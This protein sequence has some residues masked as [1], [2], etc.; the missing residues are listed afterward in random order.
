MSIIYLGN[1][2]G[3]KKSPKKKWKL[4]HLHTQKYSFKMKLQQKLFGENQILAT[5]KFKIQ[6][7]AE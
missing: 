3:L 2:G 5:S 4:D 6:I 1:D 7:E